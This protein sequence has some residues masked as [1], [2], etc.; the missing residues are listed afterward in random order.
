MQIDGVTGLDL[1]FYTSDISGEYT[2]TIEGITESGK[3]IS[4][5]KSLV[6]TASDS[7]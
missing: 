1:K 7:F 6:V 2:I 3:P 4:L 5:R